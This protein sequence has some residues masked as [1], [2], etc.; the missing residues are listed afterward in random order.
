MLL[1]LFLP[2]AHH[3]PT[4]VVVSQGAGGAA[5]HSGADVSGER[6]KHSDNGEIKLLFISNILTLLTELTHLHF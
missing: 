6:N 4:G 3:H 1:T 5:H 2:L